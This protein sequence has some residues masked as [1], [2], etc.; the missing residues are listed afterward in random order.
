LRE[1]VNHTC[2]LRRKFE[3]YKPEFEKNYF[4]LFFFLLLFLRDF[5]AAAFLPAL[6]LPA[7]FFFFALR[8]ALFTFFAVLA[9]AFV[10]FL[11]DLVVFRAEAREDFDPLWFEALARDVFL[12]VCFL[13]ALRETLPERCFA[14][15]LPELFFAYFLPERRFADRDFFFADFPYRDF[16]PFPLLELF[17]QPLSE[18]N[19]GLPL[20]FGSIVEG[21]YSSLSRRR[22]WSWSSRTLSF[23]WPS[24]CWATVPNA[25]IAER[26]NTAGSMST[27]RHLM[28]APLFE[29]RSRPIAAR[30]PAF[31]FSYSVFGSYFTS[32]TPI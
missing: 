5:L 31:D 25:K 21:L 9:E 27:F 14:Y 32:G 16:L 6:F 19:E 30:A 17:S 23:T 2:I 1:G 7:L 10:P 15:F 20:V 29:S 26:D 13:E 12:P 28:G 4:L 3:R 11:D 24:S 8:E 22:Y 18:P